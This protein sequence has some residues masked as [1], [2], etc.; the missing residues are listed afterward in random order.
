M[1]QRMVAGKLAPET[2]GAVAELGERVSE[3]G[4]D[5]ARPPF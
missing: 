4:I 5:R 2:Y 1:K 3:S